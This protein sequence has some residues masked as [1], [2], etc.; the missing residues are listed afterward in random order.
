MKGPFKI[1]YKDWFGYEHETVVYAPSSEEALKI[2]DQHHRYYYEIIS[3][4]LD[5][6][7]MLTERS[8]V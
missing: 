1:I 2:F 6:E 4:E 7:R 3:C 5:Y 8:V